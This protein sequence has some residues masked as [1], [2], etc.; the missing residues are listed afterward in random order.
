MSSSTSRVLLVIGSG[1][2]IGNAVTSLF[3]TNGS[4]NA[5]ALV[6]RSKDRLANDKAAVET[7]AKSANRQV[8]VTTYVADASD[9]AALMPVLAEVEKLGQLECV[10]YN[11][12]RVIPSA[13]FEHSEEE[14]LYDFKV[15]ISIR[16]NSTTSC[17]I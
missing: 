3:A 8:S 16:R 6:A 7:A 4:F 2:G 14:I 12:A 11:A 10:F 17:A 13:F 15:S 5:I 1:A 9:S